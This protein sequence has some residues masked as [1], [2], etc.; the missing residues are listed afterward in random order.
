MFTAFGYF[1]DEENFQVLVKI[2]RALKPGGVFVVDIPNRDVY[3]KGFRPDIVTEK[4][5]NLMIDRNS[6][7]TSTGRSYNRRIVIRDGVRRDKPFSV[8]LYNANEITGLLRQAGLTVEA[9]LGGWDSEPLSVESRRMIVVA[10]KPSV[11][12]AEFV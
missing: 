5:G 2:A 1:E 3:L 8:R 11:K 12:N 4:G 7:D 10:R 6:F 9:M